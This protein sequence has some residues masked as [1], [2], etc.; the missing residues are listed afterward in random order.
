MR[1]R[2]GS[3]C[4]EYLIRNWTLAVVQR[5]ACVTHLVYEERTGDEDIREQL[6]CL[7]VYAIFLMSVCLLYTLAMV[8]YLLK[9]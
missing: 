8:S 5:S 9:Q 1:W 3:S 7:I 4:F 2:G 6:H